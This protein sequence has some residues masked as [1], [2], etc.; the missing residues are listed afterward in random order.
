MP[1][2]AIISGEPKRAGNIIAP[3]DELQHAR[4]TIARKGGLSVEQYRKLLLGNRRQ[5]PGVAAHSQPTPTATNSSSS[6]TS[7]LVTVTRR[8]KALEAAHA[9]AITKLK[10]ARSKNEVLRQTVTDLKAVM[11]SQQKQRKGSDG[12]TLSEAAVVISLRQENTRLKKQVSEMEAFLKSSGLKWTGYKDQSIRVFSGAGQSLQAYGGFNVD[13]ILHQIKQLNIAATSSAAAK[14]GYERRSDGSY[15]LREASKPL[16]LTIYKDGIFFMR[17]PL[18]P[19]SHVSTVNFLRDISNGHFPYELKKRHPSGVQ[20]AVTDKRTVLCADDRRPG[21]NNAMSAKEFLQKVPQRK[22]LAGGEVSN[23]RQHMRQAIGLEA[24]TLTTALA[25][26]SRSTPNVATMRQNSKVSVVKASPRRPLQSPKAPEHR[27]LDLSV[28]RN[29]SKSPGANK[30][31]G[32]SCKLLVTLPGGTDRMVLNMHG[33]DTVADLR[34]RVRVE[35]NLKYKF[36]LRTAFPSRS[37]NNL[38]KT[39]SEERLVPSAKI[40]VMRV[41]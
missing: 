6:N 30:S 31:K 8:L 37:Y 39:L 24:P 15:R 18:R 10:E 26:R 16:S 38:E 28:R 19:Y 7:T 41:K 25:S 34:S 13:D 1:R 5:Q 21:D 11:S 36:E 22:I 33:A 27:Q 3:F 20:F 17:G 9:E 35:A 2:K 14:S 40:M 12:T 23:A 4:N 29:R 32:P